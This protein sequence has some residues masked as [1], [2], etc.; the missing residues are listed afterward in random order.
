M[1]ALG[2]DLQLS[3]SH[4][5][6]EVRSPSVEHQP[7]FWWQHSG[8][9]FNGSW[10]R[11][12]LQVQ[13]LLGSLDSDSPEQHVCSASLRSKHFNKHEEVLLQYH[14]WSNDSAVMCS[15]L[16]WMDL[17]GLS[18]AK[19]LSGDEGSG[20]KSAFSSM[21][22]I[23]GRWKLQQNRRKRCVMHRGQK[24][25]VLGPEC[26]VETWNLDRSTWMGNL[27]GIEAESHHIPSIPALFMAPTQTFRDWPWLTQA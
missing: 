17:D 11:L 7:Y 4:I 3:S 27:R 25:Q 26:I 2:Y 8:P 23:I 24:G 14:K 1:N 20:R 16:V 22:R 13:R 9:W 21:Y 15:Q 10:T 12:P 18:R 5:F 19:R 6:S